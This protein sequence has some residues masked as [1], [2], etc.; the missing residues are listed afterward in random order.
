MRA[1]EE[2]FTDPAGIAANSGNSGSCSGADLRTSS[3][4]VVSN[5][6]KTYKGGKVKALNNLSLEVK[7]GEALGLVGPNGAGKTTLLSCLMGF[8]RVDSG[9]ILV[10][11]EAPDALITRQVLGYLPERLTFDRWM[12][13][14]DYMQYHHELAGMPEATRKLDCEALL[15]KVEL[16]PSTW[17]LAVKKYSRGMLQRLGF[18]QALVGN[19]RYLLL[20]EPASGMDPHGVMIVRQLLKSLKD[21]GLTILLNSHQLDQIEKVCDRVIFIKS[22]TVS[23]V[24]DLKQKIEQEEHLLIR[25]LASA[26]NLSQ[27]DFGRVAQKECLAIAEINSDFARV[28]TTGSAATVNLIKALVTANFPISE[29]RPEDTRLER[30]FIKSSQEEL[31]V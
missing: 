25:W 13:G 15:E 4:I 31:N 1:L 28:S 12:T 6:T 11:G 8:L 14:R 18:A 10:D 26:T 19:P 20:D 30:L 24:E 27:D 29:V 5:I 2:V 7:P 21:D 22:G 16:H 23:R 3:G 9:S 17:S